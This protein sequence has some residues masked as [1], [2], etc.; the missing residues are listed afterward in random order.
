MII[1]V[2]ECKN[3]GYLKYGDE[4]ANETHTNKII[5]RVSLHTSSHTQKRDQTTSS[6]ITQVMLEFW[7]NNLDIEQSI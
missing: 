3:Y 4:L 2:A 6:V 7:I 1:D 5:I